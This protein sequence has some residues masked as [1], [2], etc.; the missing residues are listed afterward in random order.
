MVSKINI[1]VKLNFI[2]KNLTSIFEIFKKPVFPHLE[3]CR[4][5]AFHKHIHLSNPE[6]LCLKSGLS[7]L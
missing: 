1:M 6:N 5:S 2:L 4:I 3:S 7:I